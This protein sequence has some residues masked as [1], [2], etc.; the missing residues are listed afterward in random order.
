MRAKRVY[1]FT[2][3]ELLVVI[4]IIAILASLLLPALAKAKQS[5]KRIACANVLKQMVVCSSSYQ[6]DWDG[7]VQCGTYDAIGTTAWIKDL[8]VYAPSLFQR[9]GLTVSN[10]MCPD[11]EMD[12]GKPVFGGLDY[13]DFSKWHYGGYGMARGYGYCAPL[14]VGWTPHML[15]NT[16]VQNPSGVF[17]FTDS[18]YL[19][20]DVKHNLHWVPPTAFGSFDFFRHGEQMNLVFFDGHTESMRYVPMSDAIKSMGMPQPY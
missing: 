18:L 9:R 19:M 3:I 10:P 7:Y 16:T 12:A 13:V 8:A 1:E 14:T 17:M 5:V 6:N 20:T 4:A 11:A 15:K 2:L